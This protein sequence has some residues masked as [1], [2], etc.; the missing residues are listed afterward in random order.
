MSD[1]QV[2]SGAEPPIPAESAIP[3]RVGRLGRF[4]SALRVEPRPVPHVRAL[5]TTLRTLH[6]IA[7]AALY[8]GHVY[9]VASERL[10]PAL[11]A[12]VATGL[13]FMALEVLR[14]PVWLVQVRGAATLL[15]VA[16]VASIPLVWDARVPI[17]TA[18]IVIGA[19]TSHMPGRLRYHSLLH[20]RVVNP[21]E[22]G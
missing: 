2:H 21:R 7:I 6:L 10:V 22:P 3:G 12:S 1:E 19:V 13:A 11:V 8:G 9:G 15:K 14:A 5:R 4:S 16:L 18:V 17:L 20:G